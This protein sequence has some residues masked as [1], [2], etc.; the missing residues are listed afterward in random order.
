MFLYRE[1]S[2]GWVLILGTNPH[3]TWAPR[4][5]VQLRM[6]PALLQPICKPSS[7]LLV[8]GCL[9]D[10]TAIARQSL[11]PRFS[12]SGITNFQNI[13][14]LKKQLQVSPEWDLKA[15][16][17]RKKQCTKYFDVFRGLFLRLQEGLR[18]VSRHL[19]KLVLVSSNILPSPWLAVGSGDGKTAWARLQGSDVKPWVPA[20]AFA[21]QQDPRYAL[22]KDWINLMWFYISNNNQS[23][24]LV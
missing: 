9:H 17:H 21:V 18:A 10:T 3:F 14:S 7:R 12:V 19:V 1:P 8:W 6:S 13:G 5:V 20:D 23:G 2:L 24:V 11:Q 4:E 16:G 22:L 15:L